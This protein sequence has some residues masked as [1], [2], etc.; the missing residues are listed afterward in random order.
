[1]YITGLK[2]FCTFFEP[3][4]MYVIGGYLNFNSRIIYAIRGYFNS[5]SRIIYAI[6]GYFSSKTI[7][8]FW[9]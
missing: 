6:M 7:H 9:G 2:I 1:M 5:K 3:R 4:V 8:A